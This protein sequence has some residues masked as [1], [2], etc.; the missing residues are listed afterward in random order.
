[1]RGVRGCVHLVRPPVQICCLGHLSLGPVAGAGAEEDT[2]VWVVWLGGRI[3]FELGPVGGH[4][5]L[6]PA[7]NW[8][9][10][11]WECFQVAPSGRVMGCVHPR[12]LGL[13]P[14]AGGHRRMTRACHTTTPPPSQHADAH[15]R[16]SLRTCADTSSS[17]HAHTQM[18][19]H[20]QRHTRTLQYTRTL[21]DTRAH[22]NAHARLHAPLQPGLSSNPSPLMPP[23][24]PPLPPAH[25]P[26]PLPAHQR[27]GTGLAWGLQQQ[28]QQAGGGA[29]RTPEVPGAAGGSHA[30]TLW[31]GQV[32][33][34]SACACI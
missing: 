8:V 25:T 33:S 7:L 14:S 12:A 15:L 28:Q 23:H 11:E 24:P 13:W 29:L 6:G 27:P 10:G 31:V 16:T 34:A 19:M 22:S 26:P 32:C 2:S 1:M 3:A 30:R 5:R 4:S 9:R 18:H 20:A 21:T 17:I